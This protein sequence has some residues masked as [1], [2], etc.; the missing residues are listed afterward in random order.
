MADGDEPER[1]FQQALSLLM[2]QQILKEKKTDDHDEAVALGMTAA[3]LQAFTIELLLKCLIRIEGRD[4]PPIHDLLC[5]FNQLSAPTRERLA[6]MW[7]DYVQSQPAETTAPFERIGVRIEPELTAALAA[8]RRAFQ[9]IRY[10]HEEPGEDFVFYLGALP[11]MLK[12]VAFDLR[13]DW[14][15]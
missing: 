14:A 10:W 15:R 1:I 12:S 9:R 5:L 2:A 4:P 6:A 11:K 3:L 8:G 13:P 7:R